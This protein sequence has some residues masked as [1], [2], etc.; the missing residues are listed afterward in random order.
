MSNEKTFKKILQLNILVLKKR[1]KTPLVKPF[2]TLRLKQSWRVCKFSL[3]LW[4]PQPKIEAPVDFWIV[5]GR[6]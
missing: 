6:D 2:L 1:K 3:G 4:V 5:D